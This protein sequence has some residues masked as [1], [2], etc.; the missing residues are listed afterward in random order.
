MSLLRIV[1]VVFPENNYIKCNCQKE[2][3]IE[4]EQICIYKG[5][6]TFIGMRINIDIITCPLMGFIKLEMEELKSCDQFP[7][8]SFYS[9]IYSIKK[10]FKAPFMD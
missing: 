8:E 3:I 1:K 10:Y 5:T 2:K 4:T 7:T 9:F 6:L